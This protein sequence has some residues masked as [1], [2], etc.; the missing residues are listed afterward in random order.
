MGDVNVNEMEAIRARHSVRSFTDEPIPEGV[1]EELEAEIERCNGESGLHMALVCDEPEAF[2]STLAHYGKF[3]GVRNYL[4]L[5]GPDA[6]DLE[7]R[8]GY[9]GERIVLLAQRLGLNS[10]WV[11]LTFKKRHVKKMLRRGDRLVVVVA[12]GHGTTQ[13]SARKSKDA[14]EVCKVPAGADIPSW[15]VAAVDAALLAPT[16]MNQQSFEFEL[17]GRSDGDGRP[18][19]ALRGKGGAYSKVD[20]GIARLHFEIGA[21]SAAGEFSWE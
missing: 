17:T 10:C 9:Y 14:S 4:V 6:P 19:V 1:C 16:A 13:G 5:A 11:A 3:S 12:L 21:A 7:E 2:D 8:C 20:L 15:F 18:V